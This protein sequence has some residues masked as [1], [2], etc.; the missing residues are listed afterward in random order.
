MIVLKK[1][2]EWEDE[3]YSKVSGSTAAAAVGLNPFKARSKLAQEMLDPSTREDLTGESAIRRGLF[4]E[5]NALFALAEHLGMDIAEQDQNA[6]VYSPDY[7]SSHCL[8]DGWLDG[9]NG[10]AEVK[11]SLW[12]V[13]RRCE[14]E[15]LP[16]YWELQAQ[17]NM[18]VCSVNVCHFWVFNLDHQKGFYEEVPRDDGIISALMAAEQDFY[19]Q[20]LVGKIPEDTSD[21]TMAAITD[22]PLE[23]RKIITDPQAIT[24]ARE[25]LEYKCAERIASDLKDERHQD[26]LSFIG[27][28]DSFEFPGVMKGTNRITKGRQG[29]NHKE[30]VAA[31]SS[32]ERF[33]FHGKPYPTFRTTP[34]KG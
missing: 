19:E 2:Q 13:L 7:P 30:A 22:P 29:F 8:P 20:V 12:P 27:D 1:S 11:C 16:L 23:G 24:A 15:G 21:A 9:P 31:D 34:T 3:Y 28:A 6:F 32:L 25:F 5:P 18:A 17:H 26:L 4:G 14:R 10:I 33:Y